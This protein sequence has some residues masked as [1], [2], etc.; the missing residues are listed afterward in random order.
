[1]TRLP[2]FRSRSHAGTPAPARAAETLSHSAPRL[3]RRALL[4]AGGASIALGPLGRA[5][6]VQGTPAATPSAGAA[7]IGI[8]GAGI[9]GLNAVL[10]LHDAGVAVTLFEAADRVGGRMHSN[11]TLWAEGQ[12]SE[13]CGEL[14]NT[15]HVTIRSL[16]GRFGLPLVDLLAAEPAGSEPT[17]FFLG[18]YYGDAEAEHD[19]GPVHRTA[20]AQ[21][22]AIGPTARY[23]AMTP[24]GSLFDQMSAAQW[25]DLYVPGGHDAPLGRL[26]DVVFTTEGGRNAAELSALTLI[27]P[28]A[29]MPEL[30]GFSDERF[31]IGGGNQRLP[32]AI[33]AHVVASAPS[34]DLRLGWR[35][36]AVRRD[37][38]GVALAF[39]TADG[40]RE[41]RFDQVVLALPFSVLRTLDLTRASF[42]ALKRR[43]IGE[44]AYGTNAKL[45]LQFDAR[46]W[47]QRGAWPGVSN[48]LISTDNGMQNA[49]EV[50]RG[51]AGAAG[52]INIY[53]GGTVGAGFRPDAPFSTTRDSP[54]VGAAAKR[55]LPLM[56][57]IWPG[58]TAHYT[59]VASLSYPTG[60]LNLLGSY[61]IYTVGQIG[62]FGGYERV[63]QGNVHF[64]GDHC[65]EEF[66]GFMEGAAREGVR[67]AREILADLGAIAPSA[68]GESRQERVV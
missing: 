6:F 52:I 24:A 66:Q 62:A 37:E 47:R 32:E 46:F 8:V 67:A 38:R 25:I 18:R 26:L 50:T 15:D 60:D 35:L 22:A 7:R 40:A 5:G 49:W 10:T 34:C 64:A 2:G 65:S 41:E 39:A 9:A 16:A 4:A 54:A 31:H 48:G 30:F 59:G 3:T 33:A 58:A 28:L 12:A 44:L 61:P 53:T 17:F 36:T 14:I 19:F 63:R 29:A 68:A 1:M 20:L 11:T 23:D 27:E 21:L 13:W 55:F 57:Q 42:D 45:Q 43:A 56:E 51:Q